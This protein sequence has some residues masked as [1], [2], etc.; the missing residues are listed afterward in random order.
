[1]GLNLR[2]DELML[3]K[4]LHEGRVITCY[5]IAKAT[6]IAQHRI[7]AYVDNRVVR[8]DAYIL[9]VF[10]DYF[11]CTVGDLFKNKKTS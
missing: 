6:G 3:E 11:E 2:I 5:A 10:T 4:S 9:E 1:M 7:K 8:F